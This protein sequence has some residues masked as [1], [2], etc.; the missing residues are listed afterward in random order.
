MAFDW[1]QVDG[2]RDDMS[3]EE[4]LALLNEYTIPSSVNF[5]TVHYERSRYLAV[6]S[7]TGRSN[8]Y[9]TVT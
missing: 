7:C 1:T 2:Y 8:T 9:R 6:C 5:T 4:K 3:A